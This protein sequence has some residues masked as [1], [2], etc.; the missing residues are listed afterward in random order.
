MNYS[1]HRND[2]R[3]MA[4]YFVLHE[5]RHEPPFRRANIMLQSMDLAPDEPYTKEIAELANDLFDCEQAMLMLLGR[6]REHNGSRLASNA[7]LQYLVSKIEAAALDVKLDLLSNS[8]SA[9]LRAGD[10]EKWAEDWIKI[11]DL[12]SDFQQ[13][14]E[15]CLFRL[16]ANFWNK[17]NAE[18]RAQWE[19]EEAR[20]ARVEASLPIQAAS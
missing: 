8:V 20:R 16:R 12:V 11:H 4:V 17:S 10:M 18:V 14:F 13:R 15:L 3:A 9:G 2:P 1:D 6:L 5:S 19:E 7:A